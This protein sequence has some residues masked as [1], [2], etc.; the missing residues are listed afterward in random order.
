[1]ARKT[2]KN[3]T[4]MDLSK[5]AGVAPATISRVLNNHKS[6][7]PETRQRVF[8]VIKSTGYRYS[9]SASAL[10]KQR[11]DTICMIYEFEAEHN[12]MGAMVT[13]GV[14]MELTKADYRLA[15]VGLP[16][17]VTVAEIEQLPVAR[18]LSYDGIII[19]HHHVQGNI[20]PLLRDLGLP[21]VMVNPQELTQEN[22]ILLDDVKAG[23]EATQYLL[24]RGHRRIG[25]IEKFPIMRQVT[26]AHHS[27]G[28][29]FQGY[30]HAMGEAGL[31]I[32]QKFDLSLDKPSFEEEKY[33][34]HF[35]QW[36]E[37][38]KITAVV[39]YSARPACRVLNA[40][41]KL[42]Y[43][44]PED[45]SIISC[46]FDPATQFVLAP[47]TCCRFDREKIGKT[48]SGLILD[49]VE[50]QEDTFKSIY[51][52]S[53]FIEGKSVVSLR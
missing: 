34:R 1:M 18:S 21:Y 31:P 2:K 8:D 45:M 51:A 22:A 15:M 40:C 20:T 44:V 11:N 38:E 9:H 16:S 37:H 32:P 5:L 23:K 33:V 24:E 35:K 36:T 50:N 7:S 39:V 10:A 6:V 43:R 26:T 53:D 3:L 47:V 29:R 19:N 42:G 12:Y 46:D 52:E 30:V 25:Y 4:C 28:D 14:S 17:D 41:T 48:A 13:Q 27:Q 49:L